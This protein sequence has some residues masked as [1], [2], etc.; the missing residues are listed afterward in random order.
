MSDAV[1]LFHPV[2]R[3]A[4]VPFLDLDDE[5][6]DSDGIY[7]EE[8]EDGSF[9]LHTFQPFEA[10]AGN[11]AMA[12]MWL[13]QFQ[14]VW[15]EVHDD[16]RGVL[17]FPDTLEPEAQSYAGVVAQIGEEG[18]FVDPEGDAGGEGDPLAALVAGLPPGIDMAQLQ[19]IAGQLLGGAPTP[20]GKPASPLEIAKLFESVQEQLLSQFA[21]SAPEGEDDEDDDLVEAKP[22][23][24]EKKP[25]P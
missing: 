22:A 7:A 15:S 20:D 2:R 23:G 14:D 5:S 11:P 6:E 19:A 17:F 16:P 25:K 10:F 3:E 13:E 1:A 21:A 18:M 4:L 12:R 24:D 9:L 8:L